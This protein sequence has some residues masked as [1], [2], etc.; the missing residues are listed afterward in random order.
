V[1]AQAGFDVTA[2]DYAPMAIERTRKMLD[3]QG[4]MATL[5]EADALAWRPDQRFDAIYEQT[6]LCALYPDL[7]PARPRRTRR[8]PHP[9]RPLSQS[10]SSRAT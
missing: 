8:G 10:T 2:L 6:C 4:L 5:V 3:A 9:R 1:L 7:P